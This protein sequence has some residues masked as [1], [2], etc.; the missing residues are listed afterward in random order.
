MQKSNRMT[1][2]QAKKLVNSWLRT[3]K[4]PPIAANVPYT[5]FASELS[6]RISPRHAWKHFEEKSDATRFVQ[7]VA[8]GL[9]LRTGIGR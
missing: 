7:T 2:H 1:D 9:R 4:Q 6:R 8:Q 3:N 5:E